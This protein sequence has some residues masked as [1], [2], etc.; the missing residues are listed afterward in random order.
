MLEERS[1]TWIEGKQFQF[2]KE[3]KSYE[4]NEESGRKGSRKGRSGK[5]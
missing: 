3:E 1:Y 5:D 2:P 4:G